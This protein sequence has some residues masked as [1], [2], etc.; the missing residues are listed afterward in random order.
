MG[1]WEDIFGAGAQAENLMESFSEPD[2][3]YEFDERDKR[4]FFQSYLAVE[5][6]EKRNKNAI[7]KRR[8]LGGG[9]EIE[10]EG[11]VEETMRGCFQSLNY[12]TRKWE[13]DLPGNIHDGLEHRLAIASEE[14]LQS[15]HDCAFLLAKFAEGTAVN[16]LRKLCGFMRPDRFCRWPA[17]IEAR[18]LVAFEHHLKEEGHGRKHKFFAWH[19]TRS[20]ALISEDGTSLLGLYAPDGSIAMQPWVFQVNFERLFGDEA[21]DGDTAQ[22][23][24]Q[25]LSRNRSVTDVLDRD[26]ERWVLRMQSANEAL[27]T[28][29]LPPAFAVFEGSLTPATRAR[30]TELASNVDDILEMIEQHAVATGIKPAENRTLGV[31]LYVAPGPVA[32]CGMPA[33]N[34]SARVAIQYNNETCVL[35]QRYPGRNS[36]ELELDTLA[37]R[38]ASKIFPFGLDNVFTVKHI[39]WGSRSKSETLS[40][41]R[42]RVQTAEE[43]EIRVGNEEESFD[44]VEIPF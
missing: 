12:S 29:M 27:S 34:V 21:S 22:N 43:W 11:H 33:V 38:T 37:S 25:S 10:I 23:L 26:V 6:W 18:D 28:V 15:L 4:L 19:G 13:L 44:D 39:V 2:R 20:V 16:V 9:F 7:F 1:D 5:T 17:H 30:L 24:L 42:F 40:I 32:Q 14:L 8:P 35:G 3:K 31:T 41:N 36:E